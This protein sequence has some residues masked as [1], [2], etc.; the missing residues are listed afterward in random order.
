MVG[1]PRRRLP[2]HIKDHTVDAVKSVERAL[3]IFDCFSLER[4]KMGLSDISRAIGAPKATTFRILETLA[5]GGFLIKDM[6]ARTYQIGPKFLNY[7]SLFLFG[8][9]CRAIAVPVMRT[10]RDTTNESVSLYMLVEGKRICVERFETRRRFRPVD[11]V[12]SEAP[13]EKGAGGKIFLAFGNG[14]GDAAQEDPELHTIRERGYSLTH[15]ERDE[16]IS[17]I[18]APIFDHTGSMIASLTIAGLEA[19]YEGVR[20]AEFVKVVKDSVYTISRQMGCPE[21]LL[22][23]YKP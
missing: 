22:R 12:G 1:S 6:D 10:I 13:L 21:E 2:F 23:L 7:R 15:A 18:G 16:G 11:Y 3:Q 14:F 4:N 8:I 20:L 5:N 9:D 19:H 17:S